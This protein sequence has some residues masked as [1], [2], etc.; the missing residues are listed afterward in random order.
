MH[1]LSSKMH[2]IRNHS[3]YQMFPNT[4]SQLVCNDFF[5]CNLTTQ[6]YLQ[7]IIDPSNFY[8][9]LMFLA[10]Y[11]TL[12]SD[13]LV[14]NLHAYDFFLLYFC[15]NQNSLP[16]ILSY[17]WFIFIIFLLIDFFTRYISSSISSSRSS[18]SSGCLL[19][20]PNISSTSSSLVRSV[21][22]FHSVHI[23]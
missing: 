13:E 2:S 18:P 21:E 19:S 15:H 14:G 17:W 20:L 10:I 4:L 9:I 5:H 16:G 8:S 3:M 7:P 1:N 23:L 11:C 6:F 12:H 22:P